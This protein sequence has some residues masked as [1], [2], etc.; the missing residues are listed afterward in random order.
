VIELTEQ[1]SV[2]NAPTWQSSLSMLE[3][4]GFQIAVDDLGAGYSSLSLL[5][6]LQ[7]Q[8]IK[9]DMSIV[10]GVHLS[11][12]KQ[13]LVG[14]LCRFADASHARIIAEGIEE[15]A[16]AKVV[17][18]LGAH[19]LQGYLLGRPA[20]TVAVAHRNHSSEPSTGGEAYEGEPRAQ[21][22]AR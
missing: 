17:K 6:D 13:R 3:S 14:L 15:E 22:A 21:E 16:E 18:D 9:I 12:R 7:P 11:Q 8:F 4:F 2:L 5:A 1:D 10:R 20:M 19:L